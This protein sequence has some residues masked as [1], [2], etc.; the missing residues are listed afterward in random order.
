VCADL[1]PQA[2]NG[3]Q[4]C[5]PLTN[6]DSKVPS[7]KLQYFPMGQQEQQQHQQHYHHQQQATM[8]FNAQQHYAQQQQMSMT[9]ISH[10]VQT[11]RTEFDFNF[12]GSSYYS[13]I[14]IITHAG[15]NTN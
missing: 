1:P 15:K 2:S 5:E 6:L 14:T 10:T 11:S 13:Y 3:P 7:Q 8:A 12:N 9:N 4:Y